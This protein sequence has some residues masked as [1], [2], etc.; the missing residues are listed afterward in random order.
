MPKYEAA[1]PKSPDEAVSKCKPENQEEIKRI[2]T[3]A[4]E[5]YEICQGMEICLAMEYIKEHLDSKKNGFL[6]IGSAYGGSFHCWA[7]IIPEGIAVSVDKPLGAVVEKYGVTTPNDPVTVMLRNEMWEESFPG[8][9]R[10]V[11]GYSQE[12][13]TIAQVEKILGD[14]KLDFLFIDGDHSYMPTQLDVKNYAR[15]VRKGG[16]IGFHDIY[17]QVHR[18]ECGKVFNELPNRKWE[19]GYDN[20]CKAHQ[21]TGIGIAHVD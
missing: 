7:S 20:H 3:V 9:V 13:A 1:Y 12:E 17:H 19:T 6:E 10:I 21:P 2:Y 11:D 5:K 4:H 18:Y 16:L 8:R 15:F 14:H